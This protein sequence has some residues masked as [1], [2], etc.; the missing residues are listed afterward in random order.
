ME[1]DVPVA[2]TIGGRVISVYIPIHSKA[3]QSGDLNE[4]RAAADRLM[5]A[6]SDVDGEQIVAEFKRL[7]H[8]GKAV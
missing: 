1:S 3:A 8:R 5:E 2:V 4:L 7:R 6:L